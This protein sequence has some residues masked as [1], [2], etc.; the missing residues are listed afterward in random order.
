MTPDDEGAIKGN[1]PSPRA[2]QNVVLEL[3]FFIGKLGRK[4]VAGIVVGEVERPSDVDGILYIAHEHGDW[5]MK[6]A[7]ETQGRG[8]SSRSKPG[9]EAIWPRIRRRPVTHLHRAGSVT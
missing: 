9:L 5:Q 8:P 7:R 3:G 1:A 6:L 2:R 4:N